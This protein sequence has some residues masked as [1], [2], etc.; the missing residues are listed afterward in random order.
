MAPAARKPPQPSPNPGLGIRILVRS[1]LGEPRNESVGC[2]A[3]WPR[4]AD[5]PG[6]GDANRREDAPPRATEILPSKSK[7]NAQYVVH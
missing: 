3:A 2:A 4:T 7:A 1:A 5:E 6:H